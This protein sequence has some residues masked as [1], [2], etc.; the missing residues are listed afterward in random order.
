[1]NRPKVVIHN[2]YP[3]PARDSKDAD[4]N[5]SIVM[6]GWMF[7]HNGKNY[8]PFSTEAEAQ[9]KLTGLQGQ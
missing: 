3:K 1:M 5:Y 4:I 8:G 6:R 7:R 9:N 2:H